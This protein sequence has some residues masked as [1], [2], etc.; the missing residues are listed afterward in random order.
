MLTDRR[1]F[2]GLR[3]AKRT[4]CYY[5][6]IVKLLHAWGA[7]GMSQVEQAER[8]NEMGRVNSMG[9]P[10]S[11]STISRIMKDA[12]LRGAVPEPTA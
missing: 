11:Q 12:V 7:E 2:N 3:R 9:R 8:L 10:F 1:K 6:E 5:D 4:A